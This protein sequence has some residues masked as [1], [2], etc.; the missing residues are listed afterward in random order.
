MVTEWGLMLF[1]F[2]LHIIQLW[3]KKFKKTIFYFFAVT[4]VTSNLKRAVGEARQENKYEIR[5][6]KKVRDSSTTKTEA[7]CNLS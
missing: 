4:P 6:S 2:K 5:I 3:F 7:N 1:F